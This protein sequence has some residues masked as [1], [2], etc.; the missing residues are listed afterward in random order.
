MERQENSEFLPTTL[1]SP[2]PR[3]SR[4]N[5]WSE[6]TCLALIFME[7][8]WIAPLYYLLARFPTGIDLPRSFLILG[9]ILLAAYLQAR[10]T[11]HLGLNSLQRTAI[12]GL[13]MLFSLLFALRTLVY[14]RGEFS[15]WDTIRQFV[16]AMGQIDVWI[17]KEFGVFLVVILLGLN[18]FSMATGLP[19]PSR[20]FRRFW[21]SILMMLV[22]G[23]LS[24]DNP[25]AMPSI[26]LLVFLGSS[27]L[28]MSAARLSLLGRLRGGQRIPFDLARALGI[29]V[30]GVGMA[31]FSLLAAFL[32]RSPAIFELIFA[33]YV[34]VLRIIAIFFAILLLP[35]YLALFLIIPGIKLPAFI[36]PVLQMLAN[37]ILQ[38]QLWLSHI[39]YLDLSRLF[40]ALLSLKPAVL[41]GL[42]L[43]GLILILS[44]V[45]L[46]SRRR[47]AN[48]DEALPGP[49][50]VGEAIPLTGGSLRRRIARLVE[51]LAKRLGLRPAER[52][53]AAARIR[54]I[55]A[56]LIDQS[57]RS[58]SP[59][60]ASYTPLEFLPLL[61]NQFPATPDELELI[62]RAYMSIRYGELP[63]FRQQLEEVEAAWSRIQS[64]FVKKLP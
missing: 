33:A 19:D 55:Y 38:I 54:R 40:K 58:G 16:I 62:T 20:V 25:D 14:F 31:A 17:P 53:R 59:R 49:G 50:F 57:A 61:V 64:E 24:Q 43:L 30:F 35:V 11:D 56:E 63:E 46:W 6:L 10:L 9:V 45:R 5:L 28:A 7:I 34:W 18:G 51:R 21:A 39:T 41:W 60:P 37:L 8:C 47:N 23:L 42:V 12:F 48:Q 3:S 4:L 27:L 22:F 2:L 1:P 26:L 29:G 13:F 15:L 36:L 44:I 32:L 52:L